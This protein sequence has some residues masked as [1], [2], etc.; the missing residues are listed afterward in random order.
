MNNKCH[1]GLNPE[2]ETDG[3]LE[4]ERNKKVIRQD[5]TSSRSRHPLA[6]GNLGIG[7]PISRMK[8]QPKIG[9]KKKPFQRH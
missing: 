5:K 8:V 4:Q 1:E 9:R 3:C 2:A 6:G 7:Y